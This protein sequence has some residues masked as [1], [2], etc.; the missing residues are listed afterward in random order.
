[1]HVYSLQ[2]QQLVPL[3]PAETFDFFADAFNLEAITPPWL[4]GLLAHST[5]LDEP[6]ERLARTARVLST[7]GFGS[8]SDADRAAAKVRA[9]HRR[10]EGR[11]KHAAGPYPAGTS[12][13]ADDPDLL[14]WSCSR[15]STR[16]WSS[17]ASTS[18]L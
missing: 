8:K 4:S 15:W 7:I 3:A 1:M 10:V 18:A 2:R 5:A 9:M 11:L 14:L 13:R 17:T 16:R 6:Y 12:Y